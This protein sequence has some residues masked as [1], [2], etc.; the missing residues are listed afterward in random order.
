MNT[1]SRTFHLSYC[2]TH[3]ISFHTLRIFYTL[4]TIHAIHTVHTVHTVYTAHA[5]HSQ[6]FQLL[7]ALLHLG[8]I[9][10]SPQQVEGAEGSAVEQGALQTAAAV[11]GVEAGQLEYALCFRTM[12]TMAAG[13]GVE[14]YQVPQNV[15]Q[16]TASRD[17]LVKDL[18]FR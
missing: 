13:G 11:L 15:T 3:H 2:D 8:N 4:Y 5:F 7:A 18:Y 16:A 14:Q 10:F 17:A 1:I 6:Y 12:T 9:T